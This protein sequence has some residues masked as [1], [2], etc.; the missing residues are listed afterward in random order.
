MRT[1]TL[2][3][4]AVALAAG[5][6]PALAQPVFSVNVVGYYNITVPG[7]KF[8]MIGNQLPG[9]PNGTDSAVG[10]VYTNGVPDASVM[11]TWNGTGYDTIQYFLGFGWFDSNFNPATN[12]L[13]PGIGSFLQN[14]SSGT[15]TI[16]VVGQVPQ[17]GFTNKITLGFGVYSL[18]SSIATNI[19][20]SIMNLPAADA[21][22]Y[23]HWSIPNQSFDNPAQFF[24]GF[25]WFDQNFVQVFPTPNV[26][27]GFLYQHNGGTSNWIA[28][29]TVQ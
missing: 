12:S 22:L 24:A 5:L 9:G 17:G 29:F 8:A 20:S 13:P 26:G 25:G 3:L 16:T 15:A 6:I 4:S 1:K 28:N 10:S 2:L 7:S 19:D 18:P 21:D 14:G 11:F 27:E 23:F